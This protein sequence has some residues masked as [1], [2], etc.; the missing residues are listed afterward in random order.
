MCPSSGENCFIFASLIFVT[1]DGWRLVCWLDSNPTSRPDANHPEWQIPVSQRYSNFLLM[2]GTWMPE[3]CRYIKQ[4]CAP[5]WIYLWDFDPIWARTNI[6]V[7][8]SKFSTVYLQVLASTSL[9][10]QTGIFSG[11]FLQPKL[12]TNLLQAPYSLQAHSNY[13]YRTNQ[14]TSSD[15]FCKTAVHFSFFRRQ[16]HSQ[17]Q[18]MPFP[19]PRINWFIANCY[20][21]LTIIQVPVSWSVARF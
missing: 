16:V 1:L 19:Q 17:Q 4:N 18:S 10:S 14:T 12:S 21:I 9:V 5:S 13:R 8:P 6:F 3:T 7:F 11:K 20:Q 2:M 15:A